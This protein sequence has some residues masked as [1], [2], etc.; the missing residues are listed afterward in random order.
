MIAFSSV[1]SPVSIHRRAEHRDLETQLAQ[2]P[3]KKP[4]HLKTPA[5]A[6]LNDEFLI[7]LTQVKAELTSQVNIQIL[8]RNCQ[9]MSAVKSAQGG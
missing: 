9:Q 8:V 6:S 4:V 5:T 1:P 3:G 2:Y 7:N